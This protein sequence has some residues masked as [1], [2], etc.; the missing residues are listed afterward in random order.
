MQW[1]SIPVACRFTKPFV[2][3]LMVLINMSCDANDNTEVTGP[4]LGTPIFNAGEYDLT[5][6]GY[7]IEEFFL[8]GTATAY[9]SDG[10]ATAGARATT[11]PFATRAVVIRPTDP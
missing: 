2:I 5:A 9:K 4:V 10:D 8:T 6:L 11:A 1:I 3:A 7:H